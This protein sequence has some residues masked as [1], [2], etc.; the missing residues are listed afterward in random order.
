MNYSKGKHNIEIQPYMFCDEE[1]S[2]YEK[3]IYILAIAYGT[4]PIYALTEEHI[5]ELSCFLEVDYKFLK[6]ALSTETDFPYGQ[7]I[8]QF[9]D[10]VVECSAFFKNTFFD[11]IIKVF[12]IYKELQEIS[13]GTNEE[14]IVN[15]IQV[16]QSIMHLFDVANAI[17]ATY[18]CMHKNAFSYDNTMFDSAE[19]FNP[20]TYI[21]WL[22]LLVSSKDC[23]KYDDGILT[24]VSLLLEYEFY[25]R[26]NALYL[27]T[28]S[29]ILKHSPCLNEIVRG[30]ADELYNKLLFIL[31]NGRIVSMNVNLLYY[32]N[33]KP[34]SERSK[35]DNTTRL[36]LLYGYSNYDTYELR[37][38]FSH[39]G[40]EFVHLN[41]ATP[42]HTSCCVIPD[43]EYRKIV[44][45]YPQIKD[46]FISY[47]NR[48]ALKERNNCDLS[49][50]KSD[51]YDRI[52]KKYSHDTIFRN[53][54]SEEAI[55]K[56]IGIVSCML[57]CECRRAI[58]T[59]GM[60]AKYCFNYDI[61]MRNITWLHLA[62]LSRNNDIVD[63]IMEDIANKAWNYG[64]ISQEEKGNINSFKQILKIA[65]KAKA[66]VR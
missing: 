29:Q 39:K 14:D 53:S 58:D 37:L 31:K 3:T 59:N 38:D 19:H 63:E 62:Y 26:L 30:I 51:V 17:T 11:A 20:K 61:I 9:G 16:F 8:I 50:G 55:E 64:L 24:I 12:F 47:D 42:G 2:E 18:E 41:N 15:N 65:N 5:Q 49:D 40:Q 13:Y 21:D 66:R 60:Y 52:S 33:N 25:T 57:P 23:L 27:V 7:A 44:S 56:F 6:K 45:E 48:W 32:D 22:T 36:Q 43:S 28:I 4:Y 34:A 10:D 54:Y 46:C 35:T 1:L